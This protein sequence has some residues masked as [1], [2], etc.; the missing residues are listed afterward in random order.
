[1][2]Y[3]ALLVGLFGSLHCVGMCGPIAFVLP[4]QG[5]T[6]KRLMQLLLYHGG[7]VSVYFLLG[8]FFG[9]IGQ[10]L[11]LFGWQQGLSILLGGLLLMVVLLPKIVQRYSFARPL[12]G[13]FVRVIS[14]QFGPLLRS[15]KTVSFWILGMLNGLLPCGLVYV[16]LFAAITLSDPF[17]SGLYMFFFGLGTLPLLLS[18]FYFTGYFSARL[19]TRM[20]KAVPLLIFGMGLLLILRGLG[21]KIP[22]ISPPTPTPQHPTMQHS[23][24]APTTVQMHL[25]IN[26]IKQSK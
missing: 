9:L 22:L 4:T 25:F 14:R 10:R 2:L 12:I 20:Q 7:R 19:R 23:M 18:V 16:A 24:H 6:G 1:M 21:L 15:K 5:S 3:T 8:Y 26:P 13:W 11:H 17:S